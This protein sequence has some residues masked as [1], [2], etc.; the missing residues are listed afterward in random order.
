MKKEERIRYLKKLK[1]WIGLAL[2]STSYVILD[3][4]GVI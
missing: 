1:L 4:V 2:I 3:I